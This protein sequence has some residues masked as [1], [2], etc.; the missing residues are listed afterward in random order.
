MVAWLGHCCGD[1]CV[2]FLREVERNKDLNV[3]DWDL[4]GLL[5]GEVCVCLA[6]ALGRGRFAPY[7]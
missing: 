6:E 7:I 5:R 3:N 1:T 4:S 2:I